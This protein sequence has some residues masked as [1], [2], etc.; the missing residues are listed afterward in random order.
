MSITIRQL[1]IFVA[2]AR[3]ESYTLAAKKIHLSQPAVSMQVKQLESQ[4]EIDLF[5]Q[6]GRKL[7]LTA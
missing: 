3:C 5:E 4:L 2:V 6:L 1:Q 7:Y